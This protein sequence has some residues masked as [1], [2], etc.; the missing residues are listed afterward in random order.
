MSFKTPEQYRITKGQL[1]S[2]ADYG[3]NGAFHIPTRPGQPPFTVICSDQMGWQHISVS[4]PG[5]CPTWDEMCKVKAMFWDDEDCVMQLHPPKSQWI[6]N[7]PYC[8]HLWAPMDGQ[9]IPMP[10]SE[11]VGFK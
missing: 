6:S 7:H 8:L 5:R 11:M 4:L 3:C 9:R 10:P 1:R 2:T